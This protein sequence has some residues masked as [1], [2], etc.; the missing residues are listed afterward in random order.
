M[1][2]NMNVFKEF[3]KRFLKDGEHRKILNRLKKIKKKYPDSELLREALSILRKKIYLAQG[4]NYLPLYQGKLLLDRF[5]Q[6]NVLNINDIKFYLDDRMIQTTAF[7]A[8]NDLL[9]CDSFFNEYSDTKD[10]YRD[11]LSAFEDEGPYQYGDIYLKKGDVVIDAGSST[12]QFAIISAKCLDCNVH[13]FEPNQEPLTYLN[14]NIEL[15][16]LSNLINVHP[17]GLSDSVCDVNFYISPNALGT[18]TI[19]P[20]MVSN[21]KQSG[22]TQHMEI[23]HCITLDTWAEQNNI[24][25]IDFIKADIEG[26]ERL[27]LQGATN[28]L[29]KFQP[30]L[31]I[32]TYHLPDDPQVLEKIILD[33]NPNYIIYHGKK[34]L[35]ACVKDR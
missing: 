33:A 14:R 26:A 18:S 12:G 10:E 7:V 15:N 28:V 8:V 30:K 31:S 11:I 23:I 17:F 22:T 32:C 24:Q 25:K 5:A 9:F 6:D 20:E 35:Y 19:I 21:K 2:K 16:N 4:A 1:Y 27:M 3:E 29:K 34:K 13:A